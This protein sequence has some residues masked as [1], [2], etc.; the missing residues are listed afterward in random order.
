MMT[1]MIQTALRFLH[2]KQ[3]YIPVLSACGVFY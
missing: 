2:M 1:I 3:N